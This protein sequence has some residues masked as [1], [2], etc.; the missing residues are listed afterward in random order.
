MKN[1]WFQGSSI[2]SS[3]NTDHVFGEKIYQLSL[4]ILRNLDSGCITRYSFPLLSVCMC[5]CGSFDSF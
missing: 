2:K 1:E 5:A 4:D 3:F